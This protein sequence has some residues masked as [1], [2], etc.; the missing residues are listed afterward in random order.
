MLGHQYEF[1]QLIRTLVAIMHK[2]FDKNLA[3]WRGLENGAALPGARGYE[4]CAGDTRVALR[5]G[6]SLSG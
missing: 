4:I 6:H 5:N 3:R 1:V 2:R